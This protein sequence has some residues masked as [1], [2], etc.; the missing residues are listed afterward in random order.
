MNITKRFILIIVVLVCCVG[1][2]RTTKSIAVS[3]LSETEVISYLGDTI[4]LQ[5][6]YNSGGFLG[7]GSSLPDVWRQGI[8]IIGVGLFLLGTL[9]YALLSKPRHPFMLLAIALLF[10]GGIGNLFDRVAYG[11]LV[12]DFINFGIGSVRTGI[13][14]VADI[15]ITMGVI[16]FFLTILCRQKEER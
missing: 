3:V 1:C 16:I 6:S 10:A 12:V 15:A 8:F 14:N 4:R 9:T 13:L 5:L 11:G 7:L 2:D